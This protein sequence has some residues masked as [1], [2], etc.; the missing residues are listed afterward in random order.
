VATLGIDRVALTTAK[1]AEALRERKA[2]HMTHF[3]GDMNHTI[4]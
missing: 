3:A 4:M 1:L 2:I